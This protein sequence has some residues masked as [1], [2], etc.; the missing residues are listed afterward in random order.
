MLIKKIFLNLFIFSILIGGF[1]Y[2]YFRFDNT[3][4]ATTLI[5]CI[6]NDYTT[7][8]TLDSD[9][10]CP[11]GYFLAPADFNLNL[12]TQATSSL[13][14]DDIY[15]SASSTNSTSTNQNN[16]YN[17]ATGTNGNTNNSGGFYDQDG[18]FHPNPDVTYPDLNLDGSDSNS[19]Q[20]YNSSGTY[21]QN[22]VAGYYD[23]YGNFHPYG[24]NT[25]DSSGNY[26]SP[27]YNNGNYNSNNIY[28]QILPQ[29]SDIFAVNPNP[30]IQPDPTLEHGP[31]EMLDPRDYKYCVLLKNN[32]TVGMNDSNTGREV[33]ALQSYLYDRGF[34]NIPPTGTYDQYTT[35]AVKRFQYLNQIEVSGIVKADT[36]EILKELTCT[37]Y[38]VITYKTKP[39]SPAPIVNKVITTNKTTT[40]TTITPKPKPKPTP[41]PIST[42]DVETEDNNQDNTTVIIPDTNSNINNISTNTEADNTISPI[43]GNMYLSKGNNLYFTY[44]TKSNNP[45]ICLALNNTDCTD[46]N[47]YNPLVEGISNGFYEAIDFGN[48]WSF[49]LYNSLSWGSVGDKVR[50]YLK[51]T[52]STDQASIYIIN[53]LN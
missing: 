46:S 44:T 3:A 45:Y 41:K 19:N 21:Y 25:N 13:T 17:N 32:M 35:L 15:N 49:N 16:S 28:N 23:Q 39:I 20:D 47:N 27:D 11:D 40:V 24:D 48:L 34:L 10:T 42:S 8:I 29:S 7:Y 26:N 30:I 37:Q 53:I 1:V 6:K 5:F 2:V 33:S 50:V 52:Q 22:G 51:D 36:R 18:V 38:P 43:E 12:L 14:L 31:F 4:S 9:Q